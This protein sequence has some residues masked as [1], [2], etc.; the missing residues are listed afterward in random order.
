MTPNGRFNLSPETNM[1]TRKTIKINSI[2]GKSRRKKWVGASNP[3]PVTA[4]AAPATKRTLRISAP[5]TF[6]TAS[7]PWPLLAAVTA[8]TNSGKEVPNATN[9]AAMMLSGTFTLSATILTAGIST[10]EA[11]TTN[12]IPN[13]N[14]TTTSTVLADSSW[15]CSASIVLS[16]SASRDQRIDCHI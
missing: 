16:L 12:K 6:P 5:I 11:A 13:S 7:A 2:S 14:L 15:V 1:P 3:P 4:A 10:D 9:V 8:V